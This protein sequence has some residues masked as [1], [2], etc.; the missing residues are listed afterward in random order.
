MRSLRAKLIAAFI[1]ATILP[2]AA[3]IWITTSLLERSLGYAT[4]QDLDQTSRAL[5][6]TARQ[7]YLRERE[8]LREAARQGHAVAT[9]DAIAKQAAQPAEPVFEVRRNDE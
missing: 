3:T 4:T 2:M 1:V 8:A 9:P 6:D 7:L 5:E